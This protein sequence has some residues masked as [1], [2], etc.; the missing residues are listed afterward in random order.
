MEERMRNEREVAGMTDN[1]K[2][3]TPESYEPKPEES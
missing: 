2:N 3:I 1:D